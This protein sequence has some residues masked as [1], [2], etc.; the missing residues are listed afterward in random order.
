[1]AEGRWL[2]PVDG[3]ELALIPAGRFRM[4]TLA[5]FAGRQ[6]DELP[7]HEVTLD[8]FWIDLTEVRWTQYQACVDQGACPASLLG[9]PPPGLGDHPVNGVTWGGAESYCQWAGRRLP[10]EAEWEK[11]ARGTDARR[12]PWGWT[13]FAESSDGVRLN[14]CDV[15][16]E[17]AYRDGSV[18]DGYAETA[19]VG[20]YPAGASPYGLLDMAGNVWE[21]TADWYDS[22]AY[23]GQERNNPTG[24]E[25]GRVKVIRGG[26]WLET[27]W[28]GQL[29]T[30]RATNRAWM[31]PERGSVDL[32]F[33]CALSATGD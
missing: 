17:V 18:D 22:R 7:Q 25:T 4:G 29:L 31:A 2:S 30:S 15:N 21:W 12:Y 23:R 1:M 27:S 26:S 9:A 20:S 13:G 11:A 33:R 32:G 10:T 8:A 19:P 5:E 24:P 3:A 6:P 14:L 16:C 28:Q